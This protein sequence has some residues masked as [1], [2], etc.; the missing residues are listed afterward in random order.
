ME[1]RVRREAELPA[2][3]LSTAAAIRPPAPPR[4]NQIVGRHR[5]ASILV[6]LT[7]FVGTVVATLIPTPVY[8]ATALIDGNGGAPL[9]LPRP[10]PR[11]GVD[12]PGLG[13]HA[14]PAPAVPGAR[15]PGLPAVRARHLLRR[16]PADDHRSHPPVP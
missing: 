4:Y 3:V 6:F 1:R 5:W 13:A 2:I 15:L 7:L 10:L 16:V 8:R 14:P 11:H 12:R 9:P